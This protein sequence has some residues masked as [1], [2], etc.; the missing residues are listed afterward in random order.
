MNLSDLQIRLKKF[1]LDAFLVSRNNLF[2]DQDI[3]DD[4]NLIMQLTGFTGSAA[5]T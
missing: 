4:E 1:K 2:I 5:F 3:R